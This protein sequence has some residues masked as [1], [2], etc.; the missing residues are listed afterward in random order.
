[1]IAVSLQFWKCFKSFEK[2]KGSFSH[3]ERTSSCISAQSANSSQIWELDL[4]IYKNYRKSG[5]YCALFRYHL[6]GT[7]F[8]QVCTFQ[9]N[10]QMQEF[11]QSICTSCFIN[12]YAFF[13]FR[14]PTESWFGHTIIRHFRSLV[15][16]SI[17][18]L[19]KTWKVCLN[20]KQATQKNWQRWKQS[21]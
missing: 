13:L 9:T 1:M 4:A 10:L 3:C 14:M 18:A 6:K 5:K 16:R 2:T 7:A 17:M 20:E 19:S 21:H 11:I 15:S 8:N 12:R